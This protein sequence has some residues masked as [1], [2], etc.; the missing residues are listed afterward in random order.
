VA[1]PKASTGVLH[2]PMN[3]FASWTGRT[4]DEGSIE[5]CGP[6]SVTIAGTGEGRDFR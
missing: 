2:R 5:N 4:P 1:S 6:R 3:L